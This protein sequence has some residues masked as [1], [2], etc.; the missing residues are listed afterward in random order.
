MAGTGY[1]SKWTAHNNNGVEEFIS[2]YEY[3]ITQVKR[4]ECNR[5]PGQMVYDHQ[6]IFCMA[7]S[8]R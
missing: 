3:R 5:C 1:D 6:E 8:W 7:C 4:K 2:P